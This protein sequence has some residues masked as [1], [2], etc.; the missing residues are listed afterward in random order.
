M[1]NIEVFITNC[2]KELEKKYSGFKFTF[3]SMLIS[4]KETV[5]AFEGT[6]SVDNGDT[7]Y[8]QISTMTV[9]KTFRKQ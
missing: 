7:Q 9:H 2:V 3:S 6:L 8:G 4:G 1:S 5:V